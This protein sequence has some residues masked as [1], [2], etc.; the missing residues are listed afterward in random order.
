[1]ARTSHGCSEAFARA[2]YRARNQS[3]MV[4]RSA[5]ASPGERWASA[6]RPVGLTRRPCPV[7]S[8][9]TGD[10]AVRLDRRG[11]GLVSDPRRAV[12]G[13]GRLGGIRLLLGRRAGNCRGNPGGEA[14]P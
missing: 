3:V 8:I 2:H 9:W 4:G 7:G 14:V 10:L 5:G 12:A 6:T 1:M 11:W 13:T